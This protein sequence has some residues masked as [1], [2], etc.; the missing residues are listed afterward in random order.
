MSR[1]INPDEQFDE[2]TRQYLRDRNRHAEIEANERRFGKSSGMT[3]EQ[4]RQRILELRAELDRLSEEEERLSNPNVYQP[5]KSATG[6]VVDGTH[7]N[8]E[9]PDGMKF[10]AQ[11]D[12]ETNTDWTVNKLRLELEKRNEDR[13]RA[14]VEHLPVS[15]TKAE[16]IERLR[17]DDR[18]IAES[19]DD[20][21]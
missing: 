10:P 19:N 2:D 9:V 7:I 6:G 5:T 4:V 15:G 12:Y 16:L 18:D 13:K 21:D 8:G 17:Q 11:D 20:E 14:G 1:K 3:L